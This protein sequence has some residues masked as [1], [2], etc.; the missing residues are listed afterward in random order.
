MRGVGGDVMK[1]QTTDL[2]DAALGYAV[3][4]FEIFPVDPNTKAPLGALAPN[5]N[6]AATTDPATVQRWWTA[7]PDALIGWRIPAGCF[8]IDIDPRDGG[9]TLWN[10]L[11]DL[12]GAT[13]TRTN[14]SGGADGSFHLYYRHPSGD[15]S[16]AGLRAVAAELGQERTGI[17]LL[18]HHHRYSILPPSPHPTTGEPYTW[19]TTFNEPIA[20]C[21]QWL[22]DL[23]E[24]PPALPSP[25]RADDTYR[26]DSIADWYSTTTD[27][28]HILAP[29]GWALVAGDGDTDGSKWRHP[30]ATAE[31]SA[32]I[33]HHTLFVYSENAGLPVT[34]TGAPNGLT[35]FAAHTLINH[36]G[37]G[38]AA[39]QAAMRLPG[40]PQTPHTDL[41]AFINA[42]TTT[43]DTPPQAASNPLEPWAVNWP[44]FWDTDH[45]A[46]DFLCAPLL[47]RGRG[48]AIYAAAKTG[49]SLLTLEVAAAL[50]TG[51]PILNHEP[52]APIH[53]IYVDYE[54][55]P[56]D[57]YE[58]LEK[59]GYGP[60][61]NLDHLHYIQMPGIAPL[62]TPQGGAALVAAAQAWDAQL[63]IVDTTAR[64]T[65]GEENAMET[66][67]DFY[68]HT[69][70][71]LKALG[72]TT[73]RV[74]HSGKDTDR[75]QRGS[76]AKNDDVDIV[77]E[78]TVKGDIGTDQAVTLKATH[79]RM[80][81][82][83]TPVEMTRHQTAV[84]MH[85]VD[86]GSGIQWPPGVK[87]A[88]THLDTEGV[89]WGLSRQKVRDWWDQNRPGVD[90]HSTAFLGKVTAYRNSPE[91]LRYRSEQNVTKVIEVAEDRG[92]D[93]ALIHRGPETEDRAEDRGG[94]DTKPLVRART[95]E[96]T[97][98][99]RES[100]GSEDR[101]LPLRRG[102]GLP[103][104]RP[105]TTS[106][107]LKDNPE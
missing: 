102:P 57:L 84:P 49:K 31:S 5:G 44:Q 82:I 1:D 89:P 25:P 52:A 68:R 64:A 91:Y 101:P 54:M 67:R 13:P 60:A 97:G 56:D 75:G 50:A 11:T 27:W 104:P 96:R 14:Y 9:A 40:A 95:G 90:L 59:F 88:A 92:E 63:V 66:F 17:D 107:L 12:H 34:E 94:P 6:Q 10:H 106:W 45:L 87:D 70:M 4:G 86:A 99:D 28:N 22:A 69:F 16:T 105:Q 74:D 30:T 61:D 79:R 51:R 76:S 8:G 2:H 19:S 18:Q 20:D 71:P 7:R 78:L 46:E 80:G 93:R 77:W 48:H 85:T 81:W 43:E 36:G 15:L 35:P 55:T 103:P 26:G 29:A 53:V 98:E 24:P 39:A 72:I 32:T 47:A 37:D 21:P 41:D 62:D 42:N 23:L 100:T 3:T 38:R 83:P 65:S 73:A 33:R 58:R